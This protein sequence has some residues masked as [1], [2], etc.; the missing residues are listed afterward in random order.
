VHTDYTVILKVHLFKET[1][2]GK[3]RPLE[4]PESIKF[5]SAN[6]QGNTKAIFSFLLRNVKGFLINVC[7]KLQSLLM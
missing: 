6:S 4:Q 1:M 2:C 7:L 5:F 3:N